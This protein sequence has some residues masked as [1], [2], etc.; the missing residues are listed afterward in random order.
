M[1]RILQTLLLTGAI[2]LLG[3]AAHAQKYVDENSTFTERIYFGGNFALALSNNFTQIEVSPTIG[4]MLNPKFSV[5]TGIIYQYL[6]ANL[7]APSGQVYSVDTNIYGGRLFTRY[8]IVSQIFAYSEFEAVSFEV[9]QNATDGTARQIVPSL[10]LGAGYF[11][12]IGER[13]VIAGMALYNILYDP[14]TSPYNSPFVL[15]VGFTF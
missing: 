3:S 2:V 5:G 1:I 13:A 12:P 4:Y 11:L 9:Y 15:R 6:R 8:N 14:F 10:F 7:V